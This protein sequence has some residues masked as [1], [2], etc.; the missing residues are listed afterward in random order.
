[1]KQDEEREVLEPEVLPPEPGTRTGS[2][3][4]YKRAE[5]AFGPI[6]AG[7]FLDAIDLASM[8]PGGFILGGLAGY[9]IAS[10]YAL[11]LNRRLLL[12]FLA[13]YYCMLPATHLVPLA[14]LIGAYVHFRN[15]RP[16]PRRM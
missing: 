14:T 11:P 6:L 7:V 16:R 3:G 4:P 1:M 10:I 13:G 15:S 12:A 9:W 8:G 2:S 5:R